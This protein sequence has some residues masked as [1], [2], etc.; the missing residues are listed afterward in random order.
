M[1]RVLLLSLVYG[2]DTVS[3]ATIM[4]EVA[5]GL[6]KR[7]HA[8]TVLTSMPHYNLSAEV[9]HHPI[10]RPRLP[11]LVTE[12]W[13]SGVR[14]MRVYMPLKRQRLWLRVVDV[15][16]FH[17][18]TLLVALRKIAPQDVV[19]VVSPPITLGISGY[20]LARLFKSRL[21]YHVLELWP[22]VPVRLGLI[23]N[24]LLL[25][26]VY[27]LEAFVYR[28]AAVITCIAQSFMESL[29][30]RG[31]AAEKLRFIPILVDVDLV[32]PGSKANP[33]ARAHGL[34]SK[35]VAFYAGNIGLTQGLEILVSI[36]QELR[37]DEG[38]RIVVV[39]DGVERAKFERAVEESGVYNILCFPFQPYQRIPDTYATA[40]VCLSP[41]RVGFSYDTVPSKIYTAMAAGRPVIAAAEQGTETARLL[42]ESHGGVVVTPESAAEMVAAIR[43]LRH[44]PDKARE[45][46]Q[47]ARQW[48]VDHY[49]KEAVVAMYDHIIRELV[50]EP[51]R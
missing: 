4:T 18:M 24:P 28:Q 22:D 31:V 50:Q 15:L 6:Q 11:R 16:W 2:P 37:Q 13:E 39:G 36:A 10:Y 19:F 33:F 21:L 25:R 23:H 12:A 26:V 47:Q 30:Q 14:V 29:G 34:E 8:V 7:G 44:A 40:D 3:T 43:Q 38:I 5:H 9:R 27:A 1:A 49:S 41:M 32:T 48:V 45:M 17:V 42:K 20:V 46:G 51:G 35:F